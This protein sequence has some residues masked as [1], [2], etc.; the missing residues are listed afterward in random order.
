MLLGM[1]ALPLSACPAPAPAKAASHGACPE[2]AGLIAAYVAI[3]AE[4]DRFCVDIHAP[5]V[6]RQDAMIAAIPHF[7]IDATLAADGSRV[8][9]TREGTR[10][11]ARGI[12]SLARRYQNESPQWQDKLRRARTF[13]A[14]DLRRTRAIDRTHKAAG[15]DVVEVQEA[16]ICG[17]LD[18]TR[19]AILTFP[20]RTPSD[21]REKL[22]TLDQWLTHAELK[23]MVMSD[24]DSIQ[25]R[26]A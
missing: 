14:A 26:E 4:Y 8:W 21:M 19:Q 23:D 9:S 1:A 15:L 3:D 24:L 12:A 6:A 16:E 10:A 7:E 18:R 22:E 5:A 25:S 20:A 17:R 13:T 11:E 2:L